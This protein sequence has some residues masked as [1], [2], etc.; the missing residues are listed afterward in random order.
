MHIFNFNYWQ[1][2]AQHSFLLVGQPT[3]IFYFVGAVVQVFRKKLLIDTILP[4]IL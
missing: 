3:I 4:S 2:K 1:L